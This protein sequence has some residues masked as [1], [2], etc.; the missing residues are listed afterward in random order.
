M[1][2]KNTVNLISASGPAHYAAT[3]KQTFTPRH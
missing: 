3:H 1:L 2:I